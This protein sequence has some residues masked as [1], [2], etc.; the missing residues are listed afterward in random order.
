MWL[1]KPEPAAPVFSWPKPRTV[2]CDQCL[3]DEG[4]RAT[5]CVGGLAQSG[6]LASSPSVLPPALA[7]FA[8]RHPSP[9]S[10]GWLPH[11]GKA[12]LA[13][14]GTST[15]GKKRRRLPWPPGKAVWR[16]A[17]L[18]IATALS[19]VTAEV[20]RRLLSTA[21]RLAQ[22]PA[23]VQPIPCP[24]THP[25]PPPPLQVEGHPLQ[26]LR[27]KSRRPKAR[28][29]HLWRGE[30]GADVCSGWIVRGRLRA[31][32]KG[33][34]GYPRRVLGLATQLTLTSFGGITDFLQESAANVSGYS[35]FSLSRY[36]PSISKQP[37]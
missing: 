2:I 14:A 36:S 5:A 3:A 13:S 8:I 4:Y 10:A 30:Y 26:S 28:L 11:Y 21:A 27:G 6:R 19:Q 25:H 34:D 16:Q 15:P 9:A 29:L 20:M 1:K 31:A 32:F 22:K 7:A 18:G 24:G 17:G 37:R 23:A 35:N 33:G 12:T